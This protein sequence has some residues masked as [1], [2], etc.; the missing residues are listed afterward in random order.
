MKKFIIISKRF[1]PHC[2][3]GF[4]CHQYFLTFLQN[5]KFQL[6]IQISSQGP[7]IK[8][9]S[10]FFVIFD[11]SLPPCQQSSAFQ[12]PLRKKYVSICQIYTPPPSVSFLKELHTRF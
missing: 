6:L 8:Y 4:L 7:S 11:P 3:M 2:E 5:V 1:L 10:T 9:V 12:Y